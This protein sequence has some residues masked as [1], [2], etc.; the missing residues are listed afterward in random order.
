MFVPLALAAQNLGVGL[1]RPCRGQVCGGMLGAMA[2]IAPPQPSEAMTRSAPP[3]FM[4]Q[5]NGKQ[6][7]FAG[8]QLQQTNRFKIRKGPLLVG[9]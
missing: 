7:N 9:F 5:L 4:P 8:L 1:L 6:Q 2:R 3:L